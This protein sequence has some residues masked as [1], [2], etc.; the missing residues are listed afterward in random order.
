MWKMQ[1]LERKAQIIGYKHTY[2]RSIKKEK[3]T[4]MLILYGKYVLLP[5][6]SLKNGRDLRNCCSTGTTVQGI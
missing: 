6:L 4:K 3:Y 5:A 1:I 2:Y